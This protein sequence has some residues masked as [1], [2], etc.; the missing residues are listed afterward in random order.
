MRRAIIVA[1]LALGCSNKDDRSAAWG[2]ISPALFQ[3]ACATS[4][5][6]TRN[7]AAVGLDFSDPERGYN[8]LTATWF[9]DAMG[10]VEAGC[11]PWNGTMVCPGRPLVI[12]YDPGQSRLVNTLRARGAPRMPP[13]RPLSEADIQLVET[14]IL[15]G[16]RKTVDGPPAPTARPDAGVVSDAGGSDGGGGHPH[17]GGGG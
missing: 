1:L 16:A 9:V 4:S 12:A 17:D 5:C 13:D 8:S 15:D 2:Y 11:E 14:W 3:P 6:H 7:V 10:T